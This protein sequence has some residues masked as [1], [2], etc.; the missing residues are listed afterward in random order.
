[1]QTRLM[2]LPLRTSLFQ[3]LLVLAARLQTSIGLSVQ[4]IAYQLDQYMSKTDSMQ[5]STLTLQLRE[6][7]CTVY[8][9]KAL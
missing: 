2:M 3:K 4:C 7:L 8:L 1:M 9:A 6:L 5:N